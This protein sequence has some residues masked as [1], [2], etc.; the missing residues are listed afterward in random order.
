MGIRPVPGGRSGGRSGRGAPGRVDL[1]VRL[2]GGLYSTPM[3][4]WSALL[5]VALTVVLTPGTG[6]ACSCFGGVADFRAMLKKSPLL[7]AGRIEGVVLQQALQTPE[8]VAALQITLLR[9]PRGKEERRTVRVWDQFVG[10]S[11]SLEL[12]KLKVGSFVLIALNPGEE[13]LTELWELTGLKPDKADLLLPIHCS[14]P[15]RAFGSETDILDFV[16]S[17]RPQSH[18]SVERPGAIHLAV[19]PVMVWHGVH[20]LSHLRR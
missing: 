15:I 19:R 1:F 10:S 13:R 3:H 9:V 20:R 17:L 2:G 18:R 4:R 14:D 12:H 11:C 7:L 5:L 8:N 6:E 16:R